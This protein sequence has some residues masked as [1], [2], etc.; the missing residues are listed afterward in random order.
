MVHPQPQPNPIQQIA[1][2]SLTVSTDRVALYSFV[3][4]SVR[5]SPWWHLHLSPPYDFLDHTNHIFSES[6]SSGD[7][8]DQDKHLQKYKYKDRHTDTDKYKYLIY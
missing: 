8:I 4:P 5:P 7:D 1:K 3:C 6:L 2:L